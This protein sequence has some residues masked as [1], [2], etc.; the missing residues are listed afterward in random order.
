MGRQEQSRHRLLDLVQVSL[1]A[2]GTGCPRD[3]DMQRDGLGRLIGLAESS[4]LQRGDLIFWRGHVAIARDAET[5]VHAN[6]HHMATVIENARDAVARIR[7]ARQRGSGDQAAG[8]TPS[9]GCPGI[10]HGIRN[11]SENAAA[12]LSGPFSMVLNTTDGKHV[13][14]PTPHICGFG[15]WRLWI[16]KHR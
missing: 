16:C 4:P 6:A 5:I 7:A 10:C 8:L 11:G 12:F 15:A 3:S 13:L 14:H 2:A 9:R 1:N